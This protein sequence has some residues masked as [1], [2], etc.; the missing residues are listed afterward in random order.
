MLDEGELDDAA[1]DVDDEDDSLP[2][3]RLNKLLKIPNLGDFC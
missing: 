1:D 3:P 2:E